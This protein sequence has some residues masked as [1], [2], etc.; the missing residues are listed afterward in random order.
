MN[1]LFC[2]DHNAERGVLI[3][4]LSLLKAERGEE[5]H[6][7][8]LTMRAK[9]KS[10]SFKPFSQHAAD[11]IR[12][13]IVAD[14]PNSSL[15]LIDCTENFIKEPPTANMG[16]RFTP[17]AMLRLFA[18]ELPQIPDRILYLDDDVIIRRPVD[19]FYTGLDRDGTGRGPGLLWPLLLP[20]SK[21]DF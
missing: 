17:Y 21:E 4:V 1:F 18:D 20:Q 14:N 8:I 13:L 10:R 12:S 16:T 3:A 2:G 6:V 15:E 5:V 7:Y 9:S 19:Q 11:F